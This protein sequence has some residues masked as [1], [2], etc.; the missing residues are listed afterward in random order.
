VS[1]VCPPTA[2]PGDLE[3]LFI[4]LVCSIN[5]D[6]WFVLLTVA[7]IISASSLVIDGL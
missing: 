2:G 3:T 4:Q 1:D 6:L 7:V 5:L